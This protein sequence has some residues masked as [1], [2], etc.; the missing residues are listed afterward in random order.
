MF[1]Y[2]QVLGVKHIKIVYVESICRVKT[3]SLSGKIVY[4]IADRFVV[5]WSLLKEKYPRAKYM[6]ILV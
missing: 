6:G 4:Q 3:M 5:Q 1:Q 2:F